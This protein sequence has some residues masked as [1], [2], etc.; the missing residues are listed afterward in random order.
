MVNILTILLGVC[1]LALAQA[2]SFENLNVLQ[3][4]DLAGVFLKQSFDLTVVNTGDESAASYL[5]VVPDAKSQHLAQIKARDQR[6]NALD[7]VPL[8]AAP[9]PGFAAYDVVLDAPLPSQRELELSVE[10]TFSDSPRPFPAQAKQSESQFLLYEGTRNYLSVYP[11]RFQSTR[12][13]PITDKIEILEADGTTEPQ[14]LG[15]SGYVTLGPYEYVNEALDLRLR[16]Q[17]PLPVPRVQNLD[18]TVWVSHWGSSVSFDESYDVQNVGTKVESPFSRLDFTRM[19][20]GFS[21]NTAAIRVLRLALP[22]SHREE[23]YVDLVGNV[24]TSLVHPDALEVVPRYPIMG[25][26][27]YNFTVGWAADLK[28][29]VREVSSENY[30]LG[31]PLIGGPQKIGYEKVTNRIVLPE[32]AYAIDVLSDVPYDDVS[33]SVTYSYL[34]LY[35]RQT[36]EVTH[37]NLV[38]DM[39]DEKL[40]VSYRYPL[41]LALRK[42]FSYAAAVFAVF[43]TVKLFTA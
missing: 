25:G 16:Y 18:R 10:V 28:N 32:G 40:Y 42:P 33:E 11:T 35:G 24:S 23:Y 6:G 15:P 17:N 27:F 20:A 2:T 37:S 30:I 7:V 12:L 5:F 14:E 38:S 39:L 31:V 13:N 26:W 29:Y 22:E 4:V 8:G 19:R 21:L 3:T 43:F 36:I 34:D 1:S 41:V 9:I